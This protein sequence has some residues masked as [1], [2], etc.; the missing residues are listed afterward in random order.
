FI[1]AWQA[2][3]DWLAQR[4]GTERGA[5]LLEDAEDAG[6]FISYAPLSDPGAV[7]EWM[8]HPEFQELWS[9]V[10]QFCDDVRPHDMR[11]VGSVT[12]EVVD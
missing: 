12:N 5:V 3:A 1:A 6:R 4:L 10:M 7:I 11:V 8:S 2:S 9:E